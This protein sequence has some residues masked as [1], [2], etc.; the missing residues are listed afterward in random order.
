MA[1][2]AMIPST[3]VDCDAA[4]AVKIL[5]LIDKLEDND[6]VQHVWGN[7]EIADEVMTEIEN[8]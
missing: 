7:H 1:E 3:S 8:S 6:D 5:K 2:V 4:L